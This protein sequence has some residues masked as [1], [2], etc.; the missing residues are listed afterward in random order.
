MYNVRIEGTKY[1][2]VTYPSWGAF[3]RNVHVRSSK[4]I[5]KS[6]K[7]YN[8]GFGA[9]IEWT[10][11]TVTSLVYMIQYGYYDKNLDMDDILTFLV[12]CC[13]EYCMYVP[14]TFHMR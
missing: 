3:S 14:F 4:H 1:Q 11:D 5:I 8:P 7:Q 13:A 2:S 6:P 12:N 10:S 9:K